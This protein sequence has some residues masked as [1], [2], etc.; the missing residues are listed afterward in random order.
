MHGIAYAPSELYICC[1]GHDA[2]DCRAV[3]GVAPMGNWVE[4]G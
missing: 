3:A 1:L 4:K 2:E